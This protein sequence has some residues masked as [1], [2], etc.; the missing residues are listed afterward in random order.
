MV[1]IVHVPFKAKSGQI[2]KGQVIAVSEDNAQALL[3]ARKI[4]ELKPCRICHEYAWWLSIHSALVC[5]V[6]HPPASPAFVRKWIS[7]PDA[8]AR[9]GGA[10]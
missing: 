10:K 4:I 2:K 9:I 5:G 7:N 6:C 8:Y 1:Y 3:A